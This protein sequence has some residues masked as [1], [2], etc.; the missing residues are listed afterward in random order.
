MNIFNT[1]L[2]D[3]PVYLMYTLYGVWAVYI[4]T[5]PIF[6][7][8]APLPCHNGQYGLIYLIRYT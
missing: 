4:R 2:T 7:E 3:H 6:G 5:D 8:T 1:L